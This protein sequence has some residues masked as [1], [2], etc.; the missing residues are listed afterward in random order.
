MGA[1]IPPLSGSRKREF[2]LTRSTNTVLERSEMKN[3]NLLPALFLVHDRARRHILAMCMGIFALN[4]ALSATDARAFGFED[5]AERAR[6][7]ASTAYVAPREKLPNNLRDISYDAYR[8]IRYRADRA[9]W[10]TEKLP[11]ELQ[12]FHVGRHFTNPVRVAEVV[13]GKVVPIQ[14]DPS[15]FDYG[16]NK[17]DPGALEGA[18]FAGFRIHYPINNPAYKDEIMV[19]LGAS[20]F[21]AVGK[22]HTYGLSARGLAVNVAEPGGEEFPRFTEFWVE[23][24]HPKATELVVHALLDSRRMTG[25][26]RFVVRPGDETAIQVQSRLYLRERVAKL[27]IAPL[28]SMYLHGEN[29]PAWIVSNTADDFRPEV[30]DSDG[31]SIHTGEG[32]W[33]WRPL[34]NPKRVLVTS[35]ATRDPRGF[36]LMQRDQEFRN[37]EDTEARYEKRPSSWIEPIGNWGAGRVELVQLPTP[38]ETNDNIVAMWVPQDL[39]APREPINFSYWMRWQSAAPARSLIGW[40]EQSRRGRGFTNKPDGDIKFVVDFA[41]PRLAQLPANAPMEAVVNVGGNAELVERNAFRHAI[42]G[43][44]RMTVRV[45]RIDAAKPVELRAYLSRDG[46]ET[47]T[48]TWSY[49]IPANEDRR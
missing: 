39:P 25:A 31:L 22:G 46:K 10:R 37:Y 3:P 38:D 2:P 32:E 44:W 4:V 48:E 42:T 29:H 35:F 27:G 18:G 20:Y 26:Y 14:F 43:G 41:G 8:D 12:F 7:L 21:R 30:H 6:A 13:G 36:G 5:V 9:W 11:F 24:P 33:I 15:M 16:R 23:R 34:V 17:I 49:I 40:V 19:F 45:K 28:T 47:M 1:S